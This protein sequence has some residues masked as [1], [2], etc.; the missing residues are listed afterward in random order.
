MGQG[1]SSLVRSMV[2]CA[3]TLN[4]GWGIRGNFGHAYGA[5]IPGALAALAP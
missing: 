1:R 3:L 4:L 5:M 2:L